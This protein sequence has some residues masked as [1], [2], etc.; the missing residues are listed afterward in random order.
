MG[1]AGPDWERWLGGGGRV[2]C[3]GIGDCG[4]RSWEGLRKG[5]QARK[6][7]AGEGWGGIEDAV[8]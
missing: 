1:L 6:E 7:Q 2:I 5:A 4:G 3:A 8:G